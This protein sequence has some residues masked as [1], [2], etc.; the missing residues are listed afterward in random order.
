VKLAL[1]SG[2]GVKL[3]LDAPSV[4]FAMLAPMQGKGLL[5]ARRL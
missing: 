2:E 5:Q 3:M 4:V 1:A